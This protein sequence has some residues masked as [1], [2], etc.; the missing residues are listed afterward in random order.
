MNTVGFVKSTKEN[1]NRR[2]VFPEHLEKIE[3]TSQL[4]FEIGYGEAL[5]F[6][7]ADYQAYGANIVTKAEALTKDVICDPKIG[8]A[9]YLNDLAEGTTLF[10]WIHAVQNKAVTDILVDK[11]MTGIAWE[12]M[13]KNSRHTFWRNNKLA[14]EAATLHAFTQFGKMPYDCTVAILGR[15]NTAKGANRILTPL[16]ADVMFYNYDMEEL[17]KE[18]IETFDVI[19]NAVLWDTS[20]Q[21]HIVYRKDLKRLKKPAMI[22]DVSC[23]EAGAIETTVPTTIEKPTYTVDGVVHYAVDHTPAL[24]SHTVSKT[25]GEQLVK[26]LDIIIED[27]IHRNKVLREATIIKSGKILDE[28]INTFQNRG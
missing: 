1:E 8:D 5:G 21:D 26:Y 23:D 14:G 22:I 24:V 3:H 13:Y 27:R 4:Y 7:D 10:G 28:R 2:A 11:K 9:D 15:G 20:R 19:V 12:D 17:F 16:G 6:S 25:L 18:E